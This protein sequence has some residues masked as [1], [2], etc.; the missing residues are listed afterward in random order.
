VRLL[1]A[2]REV[3]L[4]QRVRA[5]EKLQ[6]ALKG[7]R[8]RVI[9]IL[10]LAFKPGTDDVREAPALHFIRQ[11]LERE[12]HVRAHDP[13]ATENAKK[14]LGDVNVEFYTDAYKIAEGADALVVV[15]ELPEYHHLDLK[16]L[17]QFMHTPVLLDGRNLFDLNEA[18]KA[19]FLYMGMGR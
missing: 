10:G 15:T 11:L 7:V 14:A 12:A 4:R 13:L 6:D 16:R 19:G 5:V 9:G 2:T 1:E 3:N 8:G 18:Q 17:A